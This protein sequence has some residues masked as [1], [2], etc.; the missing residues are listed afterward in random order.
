MYK[1]YKRSKYNKN[2][3]VKMVT[4]VSCAFVVYLFVL[5]EYVIVIPLVLWVIAF[6]WAI[7]KDITNESYKISIAKYRRQIYGK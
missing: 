5:A 7:M 3:Q 6:V 2:M 1:N 4:I